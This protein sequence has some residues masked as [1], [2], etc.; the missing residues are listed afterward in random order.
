MRSTN[1]FEVRNIG[2]QATVGSHVSAPRRHVGERVWRRTGE[3]AANSTCFDS[4][5]D[6][7]HARWLRPRGTPRNLTG[8]VYRRGLGERHLQRP[9]R[10]SRG[11]PRGRPSDLTAW[12]RS[13]SV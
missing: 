9:A 2:A 8:G 11:S 4:G 1:S 3:F 6:A 5:D 7:W 10:S 13:A 12:G